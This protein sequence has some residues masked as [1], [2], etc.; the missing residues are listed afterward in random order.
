MASIDFYTSFGFC[1]TF[2][3]P[4]CECAIVP[5]VGGYAIS[6]INSAAFPSEY[7]LIAGAAPSARAPLVK[8]F[9]LAHFWN[10][11]LEGLADIELKKRVFD[12]GVNMGA[13]TAV[14]LLQEALGLTV[15]GA[16]GP[17]TLAAANTA[18][19][20]VA[21]FINARVAHYEA[22]VARNPVDAK[23]LDDWLA[24]ARK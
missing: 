23:Y 13:E 4:K 9:Y 10:P 8:N 1:M 18:N 12:A 19:N 17:K 24:R 5:D 7:A 20:A 3:D 11:W 2:E 16:W 15:D 6:G 21:A 22:I 14:K